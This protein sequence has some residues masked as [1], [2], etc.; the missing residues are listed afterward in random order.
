M[1]GITLLGAGVLKVSLAYLWH[2]ESRLCACDGA[3]LWQYISGEP[4][5]KAVQYINSSYVELTQSFLGSYSYVDPRL[6]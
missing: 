4:T 2:V 3:A 5:G 6:V 1:F